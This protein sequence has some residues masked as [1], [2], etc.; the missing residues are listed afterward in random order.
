M[1]AVNDC[2]DLVD[3]VL[4]DRIRVSVEHEARVDDARA[5]TDAASGAALDI[6]PAVAAHAGSRNVLPRENVPAVGNR[7]Y[8][9]ESIIEHGNRVRIID[10]DGGEVTARRRGGRNVDERR[11]VVCRVL[12]R[13]T[14]LL[15]R[16]AFNFTSLKIF[17]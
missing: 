2:I 15:T 6:C 12:V 5:V 17:L 8:R 16:S 4:H 13:G 1:S 11:H 9:S 10:P 3:R 7:A 14:F